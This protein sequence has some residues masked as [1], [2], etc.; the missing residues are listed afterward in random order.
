MTFTACKPI[1]P[2]ITSKENI[3]KENT[4][5]TSDNYIASTNAEFYPSSYKSDKKETAKKTS[6]KKSNPP[7]KNNNDILNNL[8]ASDI[9]IEEEGNYLINQLI[10][11]ASENLGSPYLGGGTTKAG[12]DCSG[13]I[14]S[15]FKKYNIELPRSSREMA[16]IGEKVNLNNA[17]KGDLIF[18]INRGQKRINHVGMIV[19]NNQGEIKFIH[20]ATRGG[21][22]ISSTKEPY[23]QRT[24]AQANRI[25]LE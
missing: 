21:V 14:Y 18:F 10:Y 8:N 12:F 19:E 22:M 25:I 6:K 13:L 17:K 20:S 7:K 16:Q 5:I 24:F 11:N 23:Y 15:T 1:S 2:V 4:Y 3:L 9:I